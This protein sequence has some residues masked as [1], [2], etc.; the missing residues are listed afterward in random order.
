M[1]LNE[2]KTRRTKLN[3]Q[4]RSNVELPSAN[5]TKQH[6]KI[7][8]KFILQKNKIGL[9]IGSSKKRLTI[10]IKMFRYLNQCLEYSWGKNNLKKAYNSNEANINIAATRYAFSGLRSL[11]YTDTQCDT[12]E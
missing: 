12:S 11:V 5:S 2:K 6:K 1:F 9:I 8:C 7:I 4:P 3:L 10:Q